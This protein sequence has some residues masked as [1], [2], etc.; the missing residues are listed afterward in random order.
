MK[1]LRHVGTAV[2]DDN[3]LILT[4][5]VTAKILRLRHLR[6]V[7]SKVSGI[8]LQINKAGINRGRFQEHRVLFQLLYY[9]VRN[10]DRR[11]VIRLGSCHRA[12]ALIFTEIRAVG[13]ADSGKIRTVPAGFEC[14][15]HFR[16]DL[17]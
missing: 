10:L 8:Q 11:L 2:V 3:L 5:R 7:R 1:R 6:K 4:E 12:V 17:L 9:A 14:F 13:D 16:G 15:R